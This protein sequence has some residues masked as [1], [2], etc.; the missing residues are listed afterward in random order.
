MHIFPN[1]EVERGNGKPGYD[2]HSAYS[3]VTADGYTQPST[4]AEWRA[5]AKRDGQRVKIHKTETDARKAL[6]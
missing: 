1:G 6:K 2:W 4:L 3:E 5:V